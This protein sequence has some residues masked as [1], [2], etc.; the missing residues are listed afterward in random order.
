MR[1]NMRAES[2]PDHKAN[3]L[4]ELLPYRHVHARTDE[5]M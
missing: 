3:K 1:P 2:L 4:E 5:N